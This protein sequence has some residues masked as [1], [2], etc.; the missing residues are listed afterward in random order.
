MVEGG[1]RK[2]WDHTASIIATIVN[3]NRDPKRSPLPPRRFHPY[4]GKRRRQGIPITAE[5][6]GLLKAVFVDR[7]DRRTR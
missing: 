4:E 5:N 2:Q 1:Q 3:V 6:I 7:T